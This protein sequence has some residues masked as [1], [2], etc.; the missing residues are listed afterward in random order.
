MY[1][2]IT[3]YYRLF[4]GLYDKCQGKSDKEL[5]QA[6]PPRLLRLDT[7]L[8][9][10]PEQ[11]DGTIEL[12][13]LVVSDDH[14]DDILIAG[15]EYEAIRKTLLAQSAPERK[16]TDLELSHLTAAIRDLT[17]LLRARLR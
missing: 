15:R 7:I 5:Y 2:E 1:K 3:P 10:M 9:A 12:M 6:C 16:S 13:R 8:R 14:T 11:T 4:F 17:L